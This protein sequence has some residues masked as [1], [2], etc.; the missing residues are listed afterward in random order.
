MS[1]E[2]LRKDFDES[3]TFATYTQRLVSPIWMLQI[4]GPPNIEAGTNRSA[5]V[6]NPA[7]SVKQAGMTAP[8]QDVSLTCSKSYRVNLESGMR[9]KHNMQL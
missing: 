7:R 3:S 5:N 8:Q 2:R 6:A 9:R 1:F 4:A